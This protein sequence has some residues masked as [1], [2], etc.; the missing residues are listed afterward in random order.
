M[1]KVGRIGE[2]G[3]PDIGGALAGGLL[4]TFRPASE[5]RP[6]GDKRLVELGLVAAHGV[7][8]GEEM[9]ARRHLGKGAKAD[10][11]TL[12][13]WLPAHLG[14]HLQNFHIGDQLLVGDGQPAFQPA[15]SV[16]D[17]G[18]SGHQTSP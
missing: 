14:D 15:G 1:A 5:I 8:G 11:R 9:P 7:L 16:D 17:D 2:N 6:V 12:C 4:A 18:R 10:G 3:F 13:R